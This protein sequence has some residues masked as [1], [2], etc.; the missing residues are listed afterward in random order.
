VDRFEVP[1][2]NTTSLSIKKGLIVEELT[3]RRKV[4]L[5]FGELFAA[6]RAWMI[7]SKG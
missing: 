1:V 2:D 6:T 4:T 7:L 3:I 5:A